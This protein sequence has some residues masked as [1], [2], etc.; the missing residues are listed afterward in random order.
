MTES[1]TDSPEVKAERLSA[2]IE[3]LQAEN[4][5][6]REGQSPAAGT[7]ELQ[8]ENVVLRREAEM[9]E[10]LLPEFTS[11]ETLPESRAEFGSLPEAHRR[12][13]LAENPDHVR[14]LRES[15]ELLREAERL[16]GRTRRHRGD[17]GECDVSSLDDLA[18]L[19]PDERRRVL[20]EMTPRQRRALLDLPAT[21][22]GP[23]PGYL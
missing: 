14:R 4:D 10:Q 15:D 11:P 8:A 20:L 17:L 2:E 3:R 18:D 16:A 6:L 21:A 9:L 5:A 12:Q 22:D 7:L 19:S 23:G 13:L 1:A